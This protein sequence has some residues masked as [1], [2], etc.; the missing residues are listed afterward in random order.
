MFVGFYTKQLPPRMTKITQIRCN[1]VKGPHQVCNS[2]C[3]MWFGFGVTPPPTNHS[4]KFSSNEKYKR[5]DIEG[6]CLAWVIYIKPTSAMWRV[7]VVCWF[8]SGRGKHLSVETP[9]GQLL[10][11]TTHSICK[12]HCDLVSLTLHTIYLQV[13]SRFQARCKTTSRL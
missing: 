2:I 5:R 7:F 6:E 4:L 12:C 8:R 1:W 13:W 3:P 11:C 9:Y 10:T